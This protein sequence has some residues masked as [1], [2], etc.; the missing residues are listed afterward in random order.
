[1]SKL[2]LY[3][4]DLDRGVLGLTISLD[5]RGRVRLQPGKDKEAANTAMRLVG[6]GLLDPYTSTMIT[7]KDGRKYLD[8]VDDMFASSSHWLVTRDED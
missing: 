7:P 4:N 1:M 5:K 6:N 8:A 3:R 2:R